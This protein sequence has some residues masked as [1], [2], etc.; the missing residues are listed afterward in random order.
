VSSSQN[1][2]VSYMVS[3]ISSGLNISGST[4]ATKIEISIGVARNSINSSGQTFSHPTMSSCRVYAC[5]Y[6]FSPQVEQMYLTKNSTKVIR[7]TDFLSFQ[8][9]NI[10]AGGN[11]SQIL[12]NS[13]ARGRK[14]I[15]IPQIASGYNFAGDGKVIAPLNS[16]FSS[17]NCTTSKGAVTN[18]NVLVSG[19]NLYQQNLS[20][21][22][23]FYQELRKSNSI[24]GGLSFGMSSGLIN[25]N[26]FE[27]GY[28]YLVSDLS[29]CPSEASDNVAKSI[30]VQSTNSGIYPIDIFYFLQFEREVEIDIQ[31][32]TL[33]Q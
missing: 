32:G 16:P 13:I 12:T 21:T 4:P 3:P 22:F 24:N 33:I 1:G 18:Y 30:Q 8:I 9:L 11:F 26:E 14:L 5:L 25:E 7:Y 20:T 27:S 15:A 28:H 2:Q 6:D 10:S 29:R 17:S 19:S 31:T 23:D